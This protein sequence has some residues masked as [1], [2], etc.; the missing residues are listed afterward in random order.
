MKKVLV[1]GAEGQ[2]GKCIQ[3]IAGNFPTLKCYFKDSKSLDITD[4][5]EVNKAFEQISFDYCI[6]AA[7]YTNVEEAEKNPETAFLVNAIGARNV[8]NA[9]KKYGTTL[10]HLSTDYVFDGEKEGAY[11]SSDMPNPI[12]EY[13]KSKLA[14]EKYIQEILEEFYIIRTSWLYS[15]F[16]HNFYKSVLNKARQGESLFV[17]D[18][19]IGCPTNANHLAKYIMQLLVAPNEYGIYHF[20]DGQAMSWYQF[21]KL[22]LEENGL[23]DKIELVKDNNYRTFARRPRNS[24]LK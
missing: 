7:A 4:E 12:N 13:G 17:T 11:T 20:T 16:G 3:N 2:L 24:A 23:A 10:I 8:A 19:E 1:T 6:N 14:G 5:K 22:I 21:A 9:A 15:E 18:A